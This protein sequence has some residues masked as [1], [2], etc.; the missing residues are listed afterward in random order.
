M[1]FYDSQRRAAPR[2]I[3]GRWV[4][5]TT[6]QT[7]THKQ[8][9]VQTVL[10]NFLKDEL[11]IT[12]SRP[13][14]ELGS[15]LEVVQVAGARG[16]ALTLLRPATIGLVAVVHTREWI[17]NYYLYLYE[18]SA[19]DDDEDECNGR[20]VFASFSRVFTPSSVT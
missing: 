11:E 1:T 7:H 3:R 20:K 2:C 5:W 13:Q 12:C 14:E 16:A 9:L 10:H 15:S 4:I 6:E 8:T 17:M 19:Q 18:F